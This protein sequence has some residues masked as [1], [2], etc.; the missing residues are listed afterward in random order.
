MSGKNYS[1]VTGT[2]PSRL[3]SR[4]FTLIELMISMALG[5]LTVLV[6]THVLITS[7][8]QRR[9]TTTGSDAQI[10]GGLAMYAVQRDVQMAGY[11]VSS[12]LAALGCAMSASYSGTAV[13]GFPL[14]LA[15]VVIEDNGNA[16]QKITVMFSRKAGFSVPMPVTEDHPANVGYFV[17]KSTFGTSVGDMF[18]AVPSVVGAGSGCALLQATSS[19]G[20]VPTTLSNTIIPH[21][22][23]NAWNPNALANAFPAGSYLLN[24]GPMA[25]RT[26]S[27]NAALNLQTNDLGATTGVGLTED[28][29]PNVVKM[30]AMYGKDTDANGVVDTYDTT[31]PTTAAG[32][33]QVLAVRVAIVARS[34]QYEREVVT[35]AA[36]LWNLG[37]GYTLTGV[38]TTDCFTDSKCLSLGLSHLT[39]WGH[40]RY[41]VYDTVIPLRNVLWNS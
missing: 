4:G 41:K 18:V 31:T 37:S 26:Y 36:P 40:Y 10:T 7:E 25:Y 5:L 19:G 12:N 34:A 32:W 3:N 33:A 35:S 28:L 30:Q 23:T 6:I 29:F 21:E 14:V 27:V 11:G 20:G 13:T 38:T 22:A 1:D 24:M 2:R 9:T 8:G 17:V 16:G 15:P 39:D